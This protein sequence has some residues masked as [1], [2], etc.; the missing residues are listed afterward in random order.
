MV[1]STSVAHYKHGLNKKGL[2]F[3][4]PSLT[5]HSKM[6]LSNALTEPFDTIGLTKISLLTLRRLKK[7]QHNGSSTTIMKG[8]AWP[9]ME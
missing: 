6:P 1:L 4:I 7:K 3:H 2:K 5:T 8:P 9:P